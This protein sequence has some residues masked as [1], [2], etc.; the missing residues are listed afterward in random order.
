MLT[1][2]PAVPSTAAATAATSLAALAVAAA[3]TTL[4][5]QAFKAI[6]IM[7]SLHEVTILIWVKVQGQISVLLT[8]KGQGQILVLLTLSGPDMNNPILQTC[9]EA[10]QKNLYTHLTSKIQPHIKST[11]HTV[12]DLRRRTMTNRTQRNQQCRITFKRPQA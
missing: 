6:D 12:I 9:K 11:Y 3:V 2:A 5:L 4:T 7:M 10:C 1:T 8:M